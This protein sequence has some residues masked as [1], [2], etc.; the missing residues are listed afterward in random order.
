MLA[1]H[2]SSWPPMP[3]TPPAAPPGPSPTPPAP[4]AAHHASD[5]KRG[6]IAAVVTTVVVIGAVAANSQILFGIVLAALVFIPMERL[7]PLHR[8]QKIR[9]R[10]WRADVVHFLT[11][12]ILGTLAGAVLVIAGAVILRG[13]VD[14][15]VHRAITSQPWWLQFLQAAL[16][17]DLALYAVHRAF[18]E[19]PWMW[20]FHS[21]HHSIEE[22][23]WLAAARGHPLNGAVD[24]A[25]IVLPLYILGFSKATFGG[26]LVFFVFMSVFVHANVRF[27]FGPLR[28]LIATPEFHHW[29]HHNESGMPYGNYA[30][31]FPWVDALF[32]TLVLPD[33]WPERYGIDEPMPTTWAEHMAWPFRRRRTGPHRGAETTT[34]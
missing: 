34:P 4:P 33:R 3:G 9:H 16:V 12:D 30:G 19:V 29:H 23:D 17:A 10:G 28:W 8:E 15:G 18:H 31:Q 25:A 21:V 24:K 5:T 13:L 32:G 27:R 2:R 6:I 7:V 22:M 26:Y 14:D 20:R 11:G 1:D